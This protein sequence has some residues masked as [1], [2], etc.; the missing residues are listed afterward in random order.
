ME[1]GGRELSFLSVVTT[2][3]P[4]P[5][6]QCHRFGEMLSRNIWKWNIS[7][8]T[9]V[10]TQGGRQRHRQEHQN[11]IGFLMSG[12]TDYGHPMKAKIKET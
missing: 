3:S 11:P 1:R 4:V 6:S 8:Q 5:F 2:G 7:V 12:N 10:R 9:G